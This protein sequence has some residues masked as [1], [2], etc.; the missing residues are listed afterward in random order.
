MEK[1]EKTMLSD[2]AAMLPK[3]PLDMLA[4]L[5][6][7]F[8]KFSGKRGSELFFA[9]KQ[10][11]R[12]EATCWKRVID[13]DKLPFCPDGWKVEKHKG[14]GMFLYDPRE[15]VLLLMNG[16]LHGSGLIVGHNLF[17]QIHN[18]P[19]M[20]ACIL[21]FF[22]E[23]L[24]LIPVE[25]KNRYVFFWGTIYLDKDGYPY[26]RYL[27]CRG[28]KWS[29]NFLPLSDMLDKDCPAATFGR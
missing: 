12:G 26:V 8:K 7:L 19:I 24:G 6:D 17:A 16:Q 9:L 5:C 22:L 3:L 4:V 23:N 25:W 11:L 21:D 14:N 20:N 18:Q 15:V 28:N 29:D 27:F 1:H 10:L 13:S 2:L